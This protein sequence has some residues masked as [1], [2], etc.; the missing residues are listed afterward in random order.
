MAVQVYK[1]ETES[2]RGVLQ[3]HGEGQQAH[4]TGQQTPGAGQRRKRSSS[5]HGRKVSPSREPLK[6]HQAVCHGGKHP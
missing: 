3:I 4:R 5:E 2:G 6:G 1:R